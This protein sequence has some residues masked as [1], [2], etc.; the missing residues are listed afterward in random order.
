MSRLSPQG[1]VYGASSTAPRTTK[2]GLR[3]RSPRQHVTQLVSHLPNTALTLFPVDAGIGDRDAVLELAQIFGNALVA[4]VQVAFQ[5]Q[6][7]NGL[8]AF[9]NLVGHVLEHQRLHR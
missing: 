4:V 9:E 5:H 6:A 3:S 8:V 2:L 1:W 7:D